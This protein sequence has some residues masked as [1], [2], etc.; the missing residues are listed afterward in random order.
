MRVWKKIESYD[1]TRP[2]QSWL[3]AITKRTAVDAWR[4][5]GRG[6][7]SVISGDRDSEGTATFDYVVDE[8]QADPADIFFDTEQTRARV[9]ATRRALG[10]LTAHQRGVI[11]LDLQDLSISDIAQAL[12]I[13]EGTVKSRIHAGKARLMALLRGIAE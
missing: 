13:P 8:R 4:K 9:S 11:E 12:G 2:G 10:M 7:L 3:A 5:E 1:A 6:R